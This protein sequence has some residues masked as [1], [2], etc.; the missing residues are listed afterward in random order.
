MTEEEVTKYITF[1]LET[2]SKEEVK[3]MFNKLIDSITTTKITDL[4]SDIGPLISQ[5]LTP[6]AIKKLTMTAKSIPG[7]DL[8]QSL[9]KN[10]EQVLDMLTEMDD[11]KR[12]EKLELLEEKPD[13]F[14][15][16]SIET[17]FSQ[18][19][20]AGL[21]VQSRKIRRKLDTTEEYDTA[22]YYILTAV[23]TK[24][25]ILIKNNPFDTY[26]SEL[27]KLRNNPHRALA[28]RMWDITELYLLWAKPFKN[29]KSHSVFNMK[30]AIKHTVS[31]FK[32]LA[33]QLVTTYL[34]IAENYIKS[35]TYVPFRGNIQQ[36]IIP[37]TITAEQ[38]MQQ[39]IEGPIQIKLKDKYAKEFIY[40]FKSSYKYIHL[41]LF[42]LE[43][44]YDSLDSIRE[45][46][47]FRKLFIKTF[48]KSEFMKLIINVIHKMNIW[49]E[50][51][52]EYCD[53]IEKEIKE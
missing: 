33:I 19:Q 22:F 17:I 9:I 3:D 4:P 18:N 41:E 5:Y 27:L 1:L 6:S 52:K 25:K 23:N 50:L 36:A 48:S 43:L 39:P 28:E 16:Q 14:I 24:L 2:H 8:V 31:S 47:D 40:T 11:G 42:K 45:A 38:L 34:Y 15:L 26:I 53:A 46:D 10:T 21:I 7:R 44:T 32:Q 12:Y 51:A 49:T 35:I 30:E 29:I 20:L 37:A 13:D